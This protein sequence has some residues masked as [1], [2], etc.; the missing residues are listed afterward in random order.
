ML[1]FLNRWDWDCLPVQDY[2]DAS[3]AARVL[4][5]EL[6]CSALCSWEEHSALFQVEYLLLLNAPVS[7][8]AIT[9]M[10]SLATSHPVCRF[11]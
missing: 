1:L 9:F 11:M 6:L 2:L 5:L 4:C 7:A 3:S 10:E 8:G